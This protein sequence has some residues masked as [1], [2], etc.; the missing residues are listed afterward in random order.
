MEEGVQGL[1]RRNASGARAG[2]GDSGALWSKAGA[3][4][5]K[6]ARAC[7]DCSAGV[8]AGREQ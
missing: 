4:Q 8:Q 7:R 2:E 6:D 1:Q 5:A 3:A